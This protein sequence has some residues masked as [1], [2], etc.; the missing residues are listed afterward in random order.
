M[1]QNKNGSDMWGL[2]TEILW[3]GYRF[4]MNDIKKSKNTSGEAYIQSSNTNAPVL[5]NLLIFWL[6]L[7]IPGE[8][9]LD[10]CIYASP[11]RILDFL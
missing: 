6:V 10:D 8:L 9:V 4:A 5:L 2:C 11:E 1:S 7:V 3:R